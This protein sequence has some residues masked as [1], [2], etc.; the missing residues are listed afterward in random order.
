[1]QRNKAQTRGVR[2]A[3]FLVGGRTVFNSAPAVAHTLAFAMYAVWYLLFA[4]ALTEC[5]VVHV[6]CASFGLSPA[7]MWEW[8]D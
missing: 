5:S 1:M 7:P 3:W 2:A 8:H 4:R 6:Q